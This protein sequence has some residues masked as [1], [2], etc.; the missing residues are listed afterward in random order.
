MMTLGW[1]FWVSMTFIVVISSGLC[2]WSLKELR[3]LD[4]T[5]GSDAKNDKSRRE[6]K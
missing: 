2:T 3:K 4:R 6:P 1:S 5:N